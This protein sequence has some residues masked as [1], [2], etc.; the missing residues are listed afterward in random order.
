MPPRIVGTLCGC[1]LL[2]EAVEKMLR[3][4]LVLSHLLTQCRLSARYSKNSH[5]GMPAFPQEKKD[6]CYP[7]FPC[8]HIAAP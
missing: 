3:P 5:K 4:F 8:R 6:R 7:S 2:E 1:T